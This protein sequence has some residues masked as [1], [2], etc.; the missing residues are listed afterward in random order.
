M[1]ASSLCPRHHRM[2]AIDSLSYSCYSWWHFFD[3]VRCSFQRVIIFLLALLRTSR[4]K[5]KRLSRRF[6]FIKKIAFYRATKAFWLILFRFFPR[7]GRLSS[8]QSRLQ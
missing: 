3:F 6:L 2:K 5:I 1:R 8:C 4:Y 7:S